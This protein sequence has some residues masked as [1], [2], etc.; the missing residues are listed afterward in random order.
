MSRFLNKICLG[1]LTQTGMLVTFQIKPA[2]S[3]AQK[4]ERARL[5]KQGND[6]GKAWLTSTL[7]CSLIPE[8]NPPCEPPEVTNTPT[9][10]CFPHRSSLCSP[11]NWGQ[12][13]PVAMK[14]KSL[15]WRVFAQ[16]IYHDKNIPQVTKRLAIALLRTQNRKRDPFSQKSVTFTSNYLLVWFLSNSITVRCNLRYSQTD[17]GHKGPP[18]IFAVRWE[19]HCGS[20]GQYPLFSVVIHTL[21]WVTSCGFFSLPGWPPL[22]NWKAV[23]SWHL[24]EMQAELY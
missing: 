22:L 16:W 19:S 18:S 23:T 13:L 7:P 15:F 3:C 12:H 11:E 4:D 20:W 21:Q 2:T 8:N 5:R 17:R 6:K 1:Q 10:S 14:I 24:R 9:G